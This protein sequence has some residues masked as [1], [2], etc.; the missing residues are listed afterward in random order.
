MAMEVT[1]ILDAIDRGDARAAEQLLPLVYQELRRL[2]NHRLARETPGQTIQATELVHEAYLRLLG[3]SGQH[4][5]WNSREH[6][7]AAAAEAMRRILI[8]RARAKHALKRG[9]RAQHFSLHTAQL[10]LNDVP[11]EILQLDEALTVLAVNEPEKAELVKLRFFGGLTMKEAAR[12]MGISSTTA[13]RHWAYARAW[14]YH[15]MTV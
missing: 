11:E 12:A 3:P 10:S 1:Q 14:L 9:G 13:D 5:A 4:R 6:F 15:R 7:F 8:D 2:A